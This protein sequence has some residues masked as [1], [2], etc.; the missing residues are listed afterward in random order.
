MRLFMNDRVAGAMEKWGVREGEVITHKLV[1]RSIGQA[2]K[3]VEGNNFEARKRLLDYDDVMNQQRE[4]IYDSRLFALEGGEDLKGEIREMIEYSLRDLVDEYCPADVRKEEWDLAGL[5]RR[6]LLDFFVMATALPEENPEEPEYASPDEVAEIALE[7][8]RDHFHR[9]ISDFGEHSERVMSWI[10]LST[11]DD[12]WKDH[13]Y[14]LD[15]LKA[16]IGFRGWGQ[17]DPLIEYK[18]EAY[19]MFVDLMTDIRK[20][21]SSLFFRAQVGAP[22]QRRVPA[23]AQRLMYS[24]PTEAPADRYGTQART[25]AVQA[26][27]GAPP[28]GVA[29]GVDELGMARGSSAAGRP[30]EG[31]VGVPAGGGRPDPRQLLTNRGED[32]VRTP[33]SSSKAPGRNDPCPCGSGKKYKKC[34]GR[35]G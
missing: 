5:R 6:L 11:L 35:A 19:E 22:Q 27:Q 32:R 29:V 1:T 16:S 3:R 4:V 7:A 28:G 13:L 23:A 12:K 9:K 26:G 10:M 31:G 14:D 17:K 2:Q 20:T 34:C 24:G 18:K 21:V 15:H 30:P 33:A 25:G 8:A